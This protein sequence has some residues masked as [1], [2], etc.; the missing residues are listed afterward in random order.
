MRSR[1]TWWPAIR[2][3]PTGTTIRVSTDSSGSQGNG[4]S[5]TDGITADGRYV[6]FESSANNLVANDTN[7]NNDLFLHDTQTG[8]TTRVST[9][10]DGSQL[11][12]SGAADADMTPDGRYVVFSDSTLAN[13]YL[14][15]LQTGLLTQ[16]V[17]HRAGPFRPHISADGNYVAFDSLVTDPVSGQGRSPFS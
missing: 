1:R 17:T 7:N 2:T 3:T 16:L 10:S 6:L 9:N 14:K 8:T 15:D 4:L 11:N 12:G 5:F 13:L